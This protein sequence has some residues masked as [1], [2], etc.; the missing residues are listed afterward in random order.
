MTVWP[1]RHQVVGRGPAFTAG[2]GRDTIDDQMRQVDIPQPMPR[3]DATVD[4]S[5]MV[6]PIPDRV[7]G[8][9]SASPSPPGALPPPASRARHRLKR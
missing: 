2:G 4:A 6:P 8:Y 3:P 5:P 1:K 9:P 7:P